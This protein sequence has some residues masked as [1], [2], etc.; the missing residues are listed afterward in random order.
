MALSALPVE[1]LLVI[2]KKI[3]KNELVKFRLVCRKFAMIPQE[4]NGIAIY[5]GCGVFELGPCTGAPPPDT[6]ILLMMP[7]FNGDFKMPENL[8]SLTLCKSYT[9]VLPRL[10]NS[11][12]HINTGECSRM[13]P[14]VPKSLRRLTIHTTW[15][16]SDYLAMIH[17]ANKVTHLHILDVDYT[18]ALIFPESLLFLTIIS[19][20]LIVIPDGLPK[21]LTYL[22][23]ECLLAYGLT[24][25]SSLTFLVTNL[26]RIIP[27]SSACN[28]K[29]FALK[30]SL[31]K[32]QKIIAPALRTLALLNQE[33]DIDLSNI[34]SLKI[35]QLHCNSSTYI[36][37]VFPDNLDRLETYGPLH[38]QTVLPS[39]LRCLVGAENLAISKSL[40]MLK[41]LYLSDCRGINP[42][43]LPDSLELLKLTGLDIV[44]EE[45][46]HKLPSGITNLSIGDWDFDKIPKSVLVVYFDRSTNAGLN[47]I[48]KNVRRFFLTALR[49]KYPYLEFRVL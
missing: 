34:S 24:I 44:G 8:I 35:L 26:P 39:S 45:L 4:F 31:P 28:L 13:L 38:T 25:P 17:A 42:D 7:G 49:E 11:I 36:R 43:N 33:Y 12:I 41:K 2:I 10:P 30:K 16:N 19:K 47:Q 40:S 18:P 1:L 23:L 6:K 22:K 29:H 5:L 14:N 3:S 37:A 15:T 21:R 27:T 46:L 20:N 9:K 48:R 32:N